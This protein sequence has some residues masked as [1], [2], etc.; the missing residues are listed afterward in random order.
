MIHKGKLHPNEEGILRNHVMSRNSASTIIP[1]DK[2][3]I[4]LDADFGFSMF[5]SIY[6]CPADPSSKQKYKLKKKQVEVTPATEL[7]KICLQSI[8]KKF[9]LQWSKVQQKISLDQKREELKTK[10]VRGEKSEEVKKRYQKLQ[11]YLEENNQLLRE[12]I[13][14]K[15]LTKMP[16]ESNISVK[17]E[18]EPD[19]PSL[20]VVKQFLK[21]KLPKSDNLIRKKKGYYQSRAYM[22]WL[23]EKKVEED[24]QTL[25]EIEKRIRK[26]SQ[27]SYSQN[28]RRKNKN[29]N[30]IDDFYSPLS[31]AK[32]GKA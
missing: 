14:R 19:Q 11:K 8:T 30:Q 3:G 1:K 9:K 2:P 7:P 12:N 18:P 26:S 10:K 32:I 22:K 15:P 31:S 25:D 20:P 28:I 17:E 4:S 21:R 16:I 6:G 24:K 23:Y 13:K 29:A 27:N 5:M